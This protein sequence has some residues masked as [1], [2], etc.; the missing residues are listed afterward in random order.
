MDLCDRDLDAQ[1]TQAIDEEKGLHSAEDVL[2][3]VK[4]IIAE[5]ASDNAAVPCDLLVLLVLAINPITNRSKA[6]QGW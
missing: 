1:A 6:K 2:N 3:G 5:M 4:H